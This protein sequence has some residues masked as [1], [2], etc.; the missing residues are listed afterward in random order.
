MYLA[1]MEFTYSPSAV[2]IDPVCIIAS[3]F[4]KQESETAVTFK[5]DI[6]CSRSARRLDLV[7]IVYR[8]LLSL[9]PSQ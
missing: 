4:F 2:T 5:K 6:I 3:Y 9:C 7:C 8:N 1:R